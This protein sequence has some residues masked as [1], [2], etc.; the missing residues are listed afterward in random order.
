MTAPARTRWTER[1]LQENVVHVARTWGWLAVH[2][3]GNQHGRAQYDATGFPDLLLV[4]VD[5]PLIMFR[6]LKSRAGKLT[7]GQET[8]QH[9]LDRAGFDV[10]VWRPDDW[11]AIVRLLSFGAAQVA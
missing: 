8:W 7:T 4:H 3:G 5:P 6:E 10:A 2:F 11:P 1:Q 9:K